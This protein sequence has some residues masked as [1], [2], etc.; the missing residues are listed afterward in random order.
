MHDR[1]YP[2]RLASSSGSN[3]L[4]LDNSVH[5]EPIL[6]DNPNYF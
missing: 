4:C 1:Q 3:V 2:S 5:M 6:K